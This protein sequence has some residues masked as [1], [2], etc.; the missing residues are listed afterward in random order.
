MLVSGAQLPLLAEPAHGPAA[1]IGAVGKATHLKAFSFF[2]PNG[3]LLLPPA[4]PFPHH[5]R[6]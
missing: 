3:I 2:C 1:A 5:P 4:L 6:K